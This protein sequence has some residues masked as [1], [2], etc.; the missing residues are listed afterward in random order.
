MVKTSY[1]TKSDFSREIRY[2]KFQDRD[3]RESIEISGKHC[4]KALIDNCGV[5]TD[6]AI[7]VVNSEVAACATLSDDGILTLFT[8]DKGRGTAYGREIIRLCH[9]FSTER[10]FIIVN[11]S[12]WYRETT[13]LLKHLGFI[14]AAMYGRIIRWVLEKR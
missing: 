10:D 8:T 13:K 2:V 9:K 3:E 11:S 5:G 6:N 1:Y 7:I 14:R 4:S 12:A